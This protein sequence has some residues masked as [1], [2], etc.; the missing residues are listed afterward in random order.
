MFVPLATPEQF[1]ITKF[2]QANQSGKKADG[3]NAAEFDP[4]LGAS[5]DSS[6]SGDSVGAPV[7]EEINAGQANFRSQFRANMRAKYLKGERNMN[8]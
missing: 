8:D 4:E 5:P 3:V 7:N 6:L 2:L 1:N